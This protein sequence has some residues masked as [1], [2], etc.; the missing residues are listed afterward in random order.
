MK[1]RKSLIASILV[2]MVLV[3]GVGYAVISSTSLL[4]NGTAATETRDLNVVISA[5]SPTTGDTQGAVH[6][7]AD[8]SATITVTNMTTT[9]D[10]RTVTY[11]VTNNE[12][13]ADA[14]V[15][16]NTPA[17]DIVVSNS[18]YFN[19]T[20]SIDGSSNKI[21]VPAKGTNTFTVTVSLKKIPVASADS[22]TDITI[23][24]TADPVQK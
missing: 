1:N 20:T 7:P 14:E 4:V 15:Y 21:T 6:S 8:K 19:V 23:N 18:T 22:T 24:I 9:S 5:A 12:D 3:L 10:T 17:T 16:V 2:V 13:D 11:T